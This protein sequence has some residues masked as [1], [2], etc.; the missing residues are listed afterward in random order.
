VAER[1]GWNL[2]DFLS[3]SLVAVTATENAALNIVAVYNII[4]ELN[5]YTLR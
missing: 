1:T 4:V 5:I 2:C 3:D